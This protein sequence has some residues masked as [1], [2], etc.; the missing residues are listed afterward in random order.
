MPSAPHTS[1][2]SAN[3]RATRSLYTILMAGAGGA[4]SDGRVTGCAVY[5]R[6]C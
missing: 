3:W 2:A 4:L 6:S 1:A 5:Q